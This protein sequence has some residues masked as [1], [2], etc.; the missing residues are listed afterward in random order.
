M[1]EDVAPGSNSP[2]GLSDVDFDEHRSASRVPWR[3]RSDQSVK[4]PPGETH[5][6]DMAEL[7]AAVRE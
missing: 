1:N 3:W 2:P 4:R 5:R 6:G 7:Q